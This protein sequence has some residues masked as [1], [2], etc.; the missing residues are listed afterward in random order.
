MYKCNAPCSSSESGKR[1][2]LLTFPHKKT[3]SLVAVLHCS[4]FF[5]TI[6][7]P[8]RRFACIAFCGLGQNS[9]WIGHEYPFYSYLIVYVIFEAR[10]IYVDDILWC[11]HSK[12]RAR[13]CKLP[14]VRHVSGL[15]Y[16][17]KHSHTI[18]GGVRTL[19]WWT[20][21]L[22]LC[23]RCWFFHTCFHMCAFKTAGSR[24]VVSV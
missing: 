17:V 14:T 23:P 18:I 8:L 19:G 1:S 15:F 4:R 9:F 22:L 21:S 10:A 3:D 20:L 11:G 16:G 13:G 7:V 24:L 6:K 5:F 2:Q 12:A